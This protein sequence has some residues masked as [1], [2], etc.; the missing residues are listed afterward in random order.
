M[1]NAKKTASTR[2]TPG[3]KNA[4][5]RTTVGCN[6]GKIRQDAFNLKRKGDIHGYFIEH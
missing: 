6:Q 3:D 4:Q 1:V 2:A 5:E